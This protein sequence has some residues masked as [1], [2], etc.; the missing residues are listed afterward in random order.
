MTEMVFGT[1]PVRDGE[2]ILPRWWRTI[3]KL[4]LSCIL[5]LF[6]IG[7][8]L[9]LAASPPLASRN[10]LGAFMELRDEKVAMFVRQLPRGRH[11]LSYRLRAEIP[12]SFS[13]L[14]TRG[15]AM[16]APELKGNAD[17]IKL[18]IED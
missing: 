10:G 13:A 12:G 11:N 4:S 15:Y 17:E 8:L 6:G 14:P 5:L 9:A 1:H 18:A 16:Y 3:D 7:I 2:P